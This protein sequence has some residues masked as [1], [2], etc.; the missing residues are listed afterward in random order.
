MALREIVLYGQ[1]V[2]RRKAE[3][4][5]TIDDSVRELA[6]DMIETMFTADGIGLAAPQVGVSLAVCVVNNGLIEDEAEPNAYINP[7]IYEETG[8]CTIEEGCLSIPDLQ[9]DVTR[10]E[11]VRI[12]YQDIDGVE[13]DEICAGMLARVLQHEIDHLNGV[14]FIDR[15]SGIRRKLLE[16]RLK[17]IASQT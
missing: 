10:A 12:K 8:S 1:P 7:V 3:A 15:I 9:E 16:K 5:V 6:K 2:L 17:Q 11:F 13:Q 4:V 14:L